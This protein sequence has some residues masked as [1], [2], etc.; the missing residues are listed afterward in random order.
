MELTDRFPGGNIRVLSRRENTF[1]LAPDPRDSLG[2]SFYWAFRADGRPGET[3]TV[4]FDAPWV[5]FLG[6]AVS[7]DGSHYGWLGRR[8]SD[9]SF[10]YTF[11]P[12]ET[13]VWF[14]HHLLYLPERFLGFA[15]GLGL[16]VGELCR[17]RSGAAIPFTRF[18]MGDTRILLTAR[19]H[20]AES[21]G[22]YVL[23]GA[24][25]ELA[26]RPSPHLTVFCVPFVDYEGVLAGDPGKNRQPHDHNRDY[27]PLV[28]AIFDEV[29]AIRAIIDHWGF[30]LGA[31]F[32]SPW[33]RG[34]QN[35]LVFIPQKSHAKAGRLTRFG[36]V[37]EE[38][39]TE[40][41]LPYVQ[42]ND[43]P[44][45]TLWNREGSPSLA[46]YLNRSVGNDLAATLEVPF[47]GTPDC[48][49]TENALL[50]LGRCVG[51]AIRRWIETE[52]PP[53]TPQ[54][55]PRTAPWSDADGSY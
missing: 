44:P 46:T 18:G 42:K 19:H 53:A 14:A 7:R 23:E 4:R 38:E 36:R 55:P 45:D 30:R 48:P 2:G 32:H 11:A 31:D 39:M 26:E 8:E 47:F 34:A 50:A 20:A 12:G 13:R 37:L 17:T 33:H 54:K 1:D 22:S 15:A 5:G 3:L 9:F 43:L 28:P 21:P 24:L 41:A 52:P 29:G 6:P 51:R 16:P 35:D 25:A 49:V 40:D 27:N 10:T